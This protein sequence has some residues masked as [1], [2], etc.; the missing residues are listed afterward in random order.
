VHQ[1]SKTE[2]ET[3]KM[4]L[5]WCLLSIVYLNMF[6]ASLCPSSEEQDCVLPNMVLQC[7]TPYA[8]VHWTPYAVVH[9]L[10]LLTMGIMMLETCWDKRLIINIRLAASC[11]FLSLPCSLRECYNLLHKISDSFSHTTYCLFNPLKTK[12]RLLYLKTQSVPR[13]KHF[14]SRL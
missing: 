12:C 5:I 7:W 8:V 3:N 11:W 9:S 2:R 14:S 10:I 4:Q 6:R 13:C 1:E